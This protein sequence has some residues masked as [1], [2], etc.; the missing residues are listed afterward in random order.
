MSTNIQRKIAKPIKP[1]KP[2][3]ELTGAEDAKLV[4]PNRI[5][6]YGY[7]YFLSKERIRRIFGDRIADAKYSGTRRTKLKKIL[8]T[9]MHEIDLPQFDGTIT[10][11]LEQVETE[12]VKYIDELQRM[13]SSPLAQGEANTVVTPVESVKRSRDLSLEDID[14][15][16]ELLGKKVKLSRTPAEPTEAQKK[17]I[18]KIR[19]RQA[20]EREAKEKLAKERAARSSRREEIKE[21][22]DVGLA[23]M[24]ERTGL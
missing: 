2:V 5:Y 8:S 3:R 9:K 24:L 20:K 15:I 4:E 16:A 18:E 7:T 11:F 22:V 21:P 12:L 1:I 13:P 6:N 19:K 14:K 23:R 10:D 17:Q